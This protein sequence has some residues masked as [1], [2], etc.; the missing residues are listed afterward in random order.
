MGASRAG[1]NILYSGL[2]GEQIRTEVF[3]CPLYFMRL[4]HLT[5]D[6]VN[7]RG[8]GK[9]E[10]RTHQPTG[11]RAN[12]GGL[13]I[14]EM[15]RDSLCA[16]GVSAF[17]QES[18]MKRGD[19]T[20]FWVCNGCGRIPIYNEAEGLFVCPSCEGPLN[21]TGLTAD[22]LTLQMPTKQS[23]VT[24]SKVAMPYTLKLIDQEATAIGNF[25]FRIVTES[26]V[27]RLREDGWEWPAIDVEFKPGERTVEAGGEVTTVG[28][29]EEAAA[30]GP[31]VAG[32]AVTGGVAAG[33]AAGS[34]GAAAVIEAAGEGIS[35]QAVGAASRIVF[36]DKMSYESETAALLNGANTPI[37]MPG[38]QI[39]GPGGLQYPEF[40]AGVAERQV[41]PTVE[42]YYQAMKFPQD[43]EWQEQIRQAATP[44][45][46][47]RLG[48]DRT[49][50]VRADWEAIKER[51]MKSALT[52]KFQQNPVSL[53][54]LQRTQGQKLVYDNKG[55]AFW[56]TGRD[57]TGRN[58][59]GELLTEV[60]RELR[61][62]R[63]DRAFAA[64][65][66]GDP[67]AGLPSDFEGRLNAE[68]EMREGFVRDYVDRMKVRVE[69]LDGDEE[70]EDKPANLVE[71]AQGVVAEATGGQVQMVA[72][73]TE[74][75]GQQGGGAP[76]GIYMFVNPQMGGGEVSRVARA[77]SRGNGGRTSVSWSGMEGGGGGGGGGATELAAGA[78]I[79]AGS[80]ITV[81]KEG[82]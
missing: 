16:H 73:G 44:M 77:R 63:V 36:N 26:S 69:E 62:V 41:W 30:L 76:N 51:V 72:A 31:R 82:Q 53:A 68:P 14:G 28:G 25:G 17:L 33:P 75:P 27:A 47:K 15:E 80:E 67:R 61:D 38:A 65:I 2:T 4:K 70:M 12:E 66:R 52:A 24:F 43:A 35:D 40:A 11:G 58:R 81:M 57:G 74:G 56:G 10:I 45:R 18:M 42:H 64:D 54:F 32:K 6:K 21:F 79:P 1:D 55:D 22:T 19:A 48:T 71:A 8:Q 5:E 37:R 13:R 50:P 39:A 59:L 46:A 60:R 78:E 7:A 3:M 20:E 9:R 49:H 34:D 29:E 23:R